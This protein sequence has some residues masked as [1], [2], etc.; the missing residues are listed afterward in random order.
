[1]TYV[2]KLTLLER[3]RAKKQAST[4]V[5]G[6][7]WY[8]E[9]NWARVKSAATDSERFEATYTE[10]SAMAGKAL[11]DIRKGGVNAV[12]FFINSDDLLSWCRLH[13]KPNNAESHSEFVAEKL[14]S[15]K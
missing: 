2:K 6:V 7:T 1:M 14:Q 13:N 9:E 3:L 5:V 8:T 12:K 15:Q 11:A 4:S 10:W